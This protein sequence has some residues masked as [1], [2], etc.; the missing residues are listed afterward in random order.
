MD[1]DFPGETSGVSPYFAPGFALGY[2]AALADL[3]GAE[4]AEGVAR[5]FAAHDFSDTCAYGIS[6]DHWYPWTRAILLG[7]DPRIHAWKASWS[8]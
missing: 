5:F 8:N 3:C 7:R 6:P 1:L 2:A 4:E